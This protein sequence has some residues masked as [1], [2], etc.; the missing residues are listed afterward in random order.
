MEEPL[1]QP[2][3]EV[4][5]FYAEQY[6]DVRFPNVDVEV[7]ASA[8]SEV[9]DAAANLQAALATVERYREQLDALQAELLRKVSRAVAFLKVHAED[10]EANFAKLDALN[11]AL[12]SSSAS[13]RVPG[14][15]R[16]VRT[17]RTNDSAEVS[18][19]SS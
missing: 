7:L 5:N 11:Q 13:Q 16:R 3:R 14:A 1:A 15:A 2:V 4:L 17:R 8:V 9:E 12:L 19:E 10:N 18:A 6:A